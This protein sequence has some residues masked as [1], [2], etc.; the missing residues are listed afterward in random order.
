MV[1][2]N[3]IHS[4]IGFGFGSLDDASVRW[5]EAR[6]MMF[7]SQMGSH[8]FDTVRVIFLRRDQVVSQLTTS[9]GHETGAGAKK[10]HFWFQPTGDCGTLA[11]FRFSVKLVP[12][13]AV[14]MPIFQ[15]DNTAWNAGERMSVDVSKELNRL[16]GS[17]QNEITI[18]TVGNPM[19]S[20]PPDVRENPIGDVQLL[21]WRSAI[22]GAAGAHEVTVNVGKSL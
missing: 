9:D 15:E 1:E 4:N 5:A 3:W 11:R 10:L 2:Y 22:P 14:V 7:S 8:A 12:N 19:C 6:H 17:Y 18:T 20:T 21:T 16:H 13:D